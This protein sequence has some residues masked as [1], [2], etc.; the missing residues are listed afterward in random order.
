MPIGTGQTTTIPDEATIREFL[1][2][3]PDIALFNSS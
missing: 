3:N 1:I 2:R